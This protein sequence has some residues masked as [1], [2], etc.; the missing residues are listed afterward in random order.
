MKDMMGNTLAAG[1][2]FVYAALRYR[3][4]GMRIGR[5]LEDGRLRIACEGS[6]RK[7]DGTWGRSWE[8]M[9]GRPNA[10]QLIKVPVESLSTAARESLA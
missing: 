4:V 1:D 7:E 8:L 3:S 9:N 2:H 6:V 5:V 10:S